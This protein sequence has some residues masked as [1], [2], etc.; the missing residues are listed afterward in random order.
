[1]ERVIA[2]VQAHWAAGIAWEGTYLLRSAQGEYRSFLT[3]AEPIRSEAGQ[4]VRWIGTNTD[5]SE[6]IRAEAE[7]A[8]LVAIVSSSSDAIVSV[9]AE[10]RRI[11]TWNRAAEAMF[12]YTEAEAIGAPAGLL[13]P[14]E[15]RTEFDTERGVFERTMQDGQVRFDSVR[16]RKD[17]TLVD[18]S[19]SA[20]RMVSAEG[21]VIG[22]SAIFRDITE[23]KRW[24]EHQRL[25]INELNHRVKNTLATV[26]SIA[27]Q[28][29]RNA[30]S[31]AEAREAFESRL[32]ALSRAHDVL[33]RENWDG[34]DLTEIVEQAMAAYR[35]AGGSRVHIHGRAVRLSPGQALAVAMALHE[36]ATNAMKYG[37]L[38]NE[39]GEVRIGWNVELTTEPSHLRLTWAESGG[40]PVKE[41]SR[42]GFGTRLLERSLAQD[43]G[44]HVRLTFAPTGLVCT[45]EAL[46]GSS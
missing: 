7:N 44:G 8:R 10:N 29:L 30:G 42:R 46:L 23:R 18:V 33:T 25:L 39:A 15:H 5:I 22:V 19:I 37:A 36:L 32:M 1:V 24:E 21:R 26:Q 13:V 31:V 43:L 9:S 27:T 11:S 20:T 38:S 40:P 14:A 45:V 34:A 28:T 4:L 17:G 35:Q 41:P 3:R 2:E 6:R 12:G 16:R